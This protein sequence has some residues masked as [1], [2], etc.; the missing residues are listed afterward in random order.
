MFPHNLDMG[1]PYPSS[2][3]GN[4]QRTLSN[5]VPTMISILIS[6]FTVTANLFENFEPQSGIDLLP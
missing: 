1:N 4:I 3:F 6:F 2:F 5:N